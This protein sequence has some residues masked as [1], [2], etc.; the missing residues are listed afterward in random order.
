MLPEN[1]LNMNTPRTNRRNFLLFMSLVGVASLA[2]WIVVRLLEFQH[3]PPN[4]PLF[5]SQVDAI[6]FETLKTI[7]ETSF[8]GCLIGLIIDQYQE[9]ISERKDYF[10]KTVSDAGVIGVYTS[11][12]AP[13]LIR[14]LASAIQDSSVQIT[15]IGLGLS[16]LLN[17]QLLDAIA[18]QLISE[19][20]LNVNVIVGSPDNAGV[21]ARVNEEKLCHE[22]LGFA[23]QAYWPT[24]FP[25]EI[26]SQI[27]AKLN[28]KTKKRLKV[29]TTKILPMTGVL[30][31]DRRLFVFLYGA[32]NMRGGS[33]SVWLELDS[34]EKKSAFVEWAEKVIDFHLNIESSLNF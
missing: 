15:C 2:L 12:E 23:Y 19:S 24:R 14:A 28:S 3:E 5:D 18:Q 33:Q 4:P 29:W 21:S 13:E 27:S 32:P 11:S 6:L 34:R 7:F 1:D 17:R 20:K 30:R 9:R 26:E 10:Q 25:K 16:A 8:G 31:F 22:H